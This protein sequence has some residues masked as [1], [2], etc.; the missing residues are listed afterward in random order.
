MEKKSCG[1]E[2]RPF[3]NLIKGVRNGREAT[4]EAHV[5]LLIGK[6]VE[7]LV[8]CGRRQAVLF[9]VPCIHI[10]LLSVRVF[11][12]SEVRG[13]CGEL[14]TIILP[15]LRIVLQS[16]TPAHSAPA[17]VAAVADGGRDAALAAAAPMHHFS[18]CCCCCCCSSCEFEWL[19]RL[20]L[21]LLR[22]VCC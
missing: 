6:L 14:N 22:E 19:D 9:N 18:L 21:L 16:P 12:R 17:H 2:I 11:K 5:K 3:S 13:I 8:R 7:Q 1:F 10:V 15:D 20:T 4:V